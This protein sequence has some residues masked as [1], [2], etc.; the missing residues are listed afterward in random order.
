VDLRH[1]FLLLDRTKN[2]ERREVPI[3][4]TLRAALQGLTRRLDVPYVFHDPLT[5]RRYRDVKRSFR[6]ACRRAGI[7]DF[8]LHDCRHTFASH[9]VMAGADLTT[10]KELLGHKTLAMTLRYSHLT[11]SHKMRAVDLL[12]LALNETKCTKS[13][14]KRVADK[15]PISQPLDFIGAGGG[16]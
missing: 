5:G 1:G 2:G 4:A 13:A 9:L 14:Q 7:K 15:Y 12:D 16:T 8:R 10:V 6:S 3:N 11:S